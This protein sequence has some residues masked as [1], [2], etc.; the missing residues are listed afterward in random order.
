MRPNPVKAKLKAGQSVLGTFVKIPDPSVVEV[1]ALA[2]LDFFVLDNEHAVLDPVQA[3]HLVRAAECFGIAPLIRVGEN[4]PVAILQALDLG[5]LGVQ[6]PNVDDEAGAR[7]LVASV[8]YVP[9]GARGLSPSVRACRYGTMAVADY[10]RE[11]NEGTLTVAHCESRTG[12]G[13]LEAVTRVPGLD[14]IFVGPM[15]LSQSFG[16]PGE[17]GSPEVAGAVEKA[18]S[19]V[20]KSGLA[21]G[22]T[23]ASPAAAKDLMAR[24]FRYV[25][26]ASDQAMILSWAKNFVREAAGA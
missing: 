12:L 14:V 5:W 25:L 23:A 10:V 24:G 2:G 9:Q 8:K 1:L 13:N 20:L 6:V 21:A 17:V 18:L 15:D 19:I 26:A 7:S 22:T 11:A 16:R 3:G 4:S